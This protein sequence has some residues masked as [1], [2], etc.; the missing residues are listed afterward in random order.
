MQKIGFLF[1]IT[2]L[3]PVSN[4]G[5]YVPNGLLL[6]PPSAFFII[7]EILIKAYILSLESVDF[8][9]AF[10]ELKQINNKSDLKA[11]VL[12]N[13][14]INKNI[15]QKNIWVKRDDDLFFKMLFA[16]VFTITMIVT[17]KTSGS[18]RIDTLDK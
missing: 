16:M 6:L 15:Q 1:G 9:D 11:Q 14:S 2:I 13:I 5:W 7:G 10:I 17:F 18:S 12:I 4:G 8:N 3:D